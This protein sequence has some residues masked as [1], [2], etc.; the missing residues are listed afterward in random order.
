MTFEKHCDEAH[1][2]WGE[3]FEQVHH[4]L[5]EFAGQPPWGS[6]HRKFRHHLAGVSEVRARWGEVA[7]QAALQHI[8]ADLRQEGWKTG[9]PFPKD[10]RDYVRMGFW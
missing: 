4:W 5:D 2:T 3:P 1:N 7:A 10:E 8:E 9:D 6:R